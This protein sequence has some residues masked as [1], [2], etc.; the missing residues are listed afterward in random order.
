MLIKGIKII[1]C[2]CLVICCVA[3]G[4]F[5]TNR[6]RAFDSGAIAPLNAEEDSNCRSI[7]LRDKAIIGF[8]KYGFREKIKIDSPTLISQYIVEDYSL[9]NV[10]YGIY[11]DKQLTMPV[12]EIDMDYVL[13]S[14]ADMEEGIENAS[15]SDFTSEQYTL[16]EP[17]TYYLGLYTSKFFDFSDLRYGSQFALYEKEIEAVEGELYKWTFPENEDGEL[18]V[19]LRVPENRSGIS[20]MVENYPVPLKIELCDSDRRRIGT[21]IYADDYQIQDRLNFDVSRSQYAYIRLSWKASQ[22]QLDGKIQVCKL[23]IIE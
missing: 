5:I 4:L 14:L 3:A 20:I 16:L 22:R 11:K 6:T 1:A 9:N 23:K 15:L 7:S 21:P 8:G 13:K 12:K 2:I 19:R 18:W 10:R 17:G